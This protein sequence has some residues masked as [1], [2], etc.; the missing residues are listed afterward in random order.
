[1]LY[2]L[3]LQGQLAHQALQGHAVHIIASKINLRIPV[4]FLFR[5][6]VPIGFGCQIKNHLVP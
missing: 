5:Q 3:R 1:M 2:M 4:A 6:L